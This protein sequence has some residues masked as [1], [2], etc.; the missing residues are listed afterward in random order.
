[1]RRSVNENRTLYDAKREHA[2]QIDTL[3]NKLRQANE[4]LDY[5]KQKLT[6]IEAQNHELRTTG[7]SG[8]SK[9]VR[10]LEN[11]VEI[12]RSQVKELGG[13]SAGKL[14][15]KNMDFKDFKKQLSQDEQ[16]QLQREL[17]Q[18][19]MIIKGYMDENA[20]AMKKVNELEQ[21]IKSEVAKNQNYEKEL[22]HFKIKNMK[23]R[24]GK[25]EDEIVITNEEHQ[26]LN[27]ISIK[28]LKELKDTLKRLQEENQRLKYGAESSVY[29]LNDQLEQKIKDQETKFAKE[30]NELHAK[31]VNYNDTKDKVA[32]LQKKVADQTE[33]IYNFQ[34]KEK[35]LKD[36]VKTLEDKLKSNG[37]P[38][39][40]KRPG[41]EQDSNEVKL[42][43]DQKQQL[44]RQIDDLRASNQ[45]LQL[46][47]EDLENENHKVRMQRAEAMNMVQKQ[48][49]QT[50]PRQNNNMR[51]MFYAEQDAPAEDYKNPF[52]TISPDK[53]TPVKVESKSV[54]EV[55]SIFRG[56]QD[57]SVIFGQKSKAKLNEV[58]SILFTVLDQQMKVEDLK[59]FNRHINFRY[60]QTELGDDVEMVVNEDEMDRKILETVLSKLPPT[61]TPPRE[62]PRQA[63]QQNNLMMTGGVDPAI[64]Q[65]LQQQKMAESEQSK[66]M[67]AHLKDQ[68]EGLKQEIKN[69]KGQKNEDYDHAITKVGRLQREIAAME[70]ERTSLLQKIN[71]LEAQKTRLE[72]VFKS[73]MKSDKMDLIDEVQLL[74][75]RIEY[76][77]EQNSQRSKNDYLENKEPY[78]REIEMLKSKL[79]QEREMRNQ[80]VQKKN[81]EVSY[82]KAEL[83]A[84]LSEL[85]RKVNKK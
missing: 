57:L 36:K 14:D 67:I 32:S 40:P 24:E 80:I 81:A 60:N 59:S 28:Q 2:I 10:E 83:D 5:Y 34:A 27:T 11:E 1:M 82:F 43:K 21:R 53:E 61:P 58:Y 25:F 31:L 4:E 45:E 65:M 26:T 6:K 37:F 9:R 78:L 52:S 19:D 70:D 15:N 38:Q 56:I 84:L 62:R 74:V 69:L 30:K 17:G 64:V 20:K 13:N 73:T 42:L 55:L 63:P 41:S 50:P 29:Q 66:A 22:N 79:V 46:K 39:Y 3:D 85:S 75:R 8:D 33:T 16:V 71:K 68:I 77:E 47:I 51:Q 12:L 54:S 35:D 72:S 49:K 23:E 18:L 7:G 48:Q 76:L 44:A